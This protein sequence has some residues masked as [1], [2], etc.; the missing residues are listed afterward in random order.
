ML[1][2][3]LKDGLNDGHGLSDGS[4]LMNLKSLVRDIP[5]FPKEGILFRDISPLLASP[6]ALSYV[7]SQLVAQTDLSAIDSFA[8]IESRGF[9]LAA[10]LSGIHKRGFVPIRKVG[11]LPPPTMQQKYTLEYG[12]ACIEMNP[13]SSRIMIVD[14]VLATGGTLHAAIELAG[15]AGYQVNHVA[16]LIN[17]KGLNNLK[18]K[19]QPVDSVLDY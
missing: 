5:N 10:L 6:E 16:V 18:F 4:F 8:G 2:E 13:G 9:I 1:N 15:L 14:D 19:G 3:G 12:E 7:A 11:K 17:L